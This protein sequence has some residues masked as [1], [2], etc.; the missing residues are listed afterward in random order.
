MGW[1]SMESDPRETNVA[2]V[3]QSERLMGRL[4]REGNDTVFV[5]HY[6]VEE[7][8]PGIAFHLQT[9]TRSYRQGGGAVHPFFAGLLPEGAR[10]T[11][12]SARLKTSLD[13][14]FTLLVAV[15]EDCVGDV[16][17]VP[18]DAPP[19]AP[20]AVALGNPANLDF[21]GLFARSIGQEEDDYDHVALAGVQEK[22]SAAMV[23][24]PVGSSSAILKLSPP[25]LPR[26]VENEAFFLRMA[27]DLGVRVNRAE[28][29]R[30]RH[31]R[32]G[33]MVQ[34]FDRFATGRSGYLS[35]THQE[36]AC[37]FTNVFPA[38]KYRL[39]S[40]DVAEG[41]VAH[42]SVPPLAIREFVRQSAMNYL[43]A[44][45]DFH[46]KN[47][48]L[49]RSPKTGLIEVT[50]AY[51]VLSTLPY[52]DDRMAMK[53]DGR[54]KNLSRRTFVEF[55]ARYGVAPKAIHTLLD[56]MCEA[57]PP[58]IARLE[59]IGFDERPTAHLRREVLRRREQLG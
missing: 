23:S 29:V 38:A 43:I 13:D 21:D 25:R 30:D 40:K 9:T 8:E 44:N 32:S 53:M 51:D 14:M 12:L 5:Y 41:L 7:G 6:S 27:D 34:R 22:V 52:G 20:A 49:Y 28:L 4:E 56:R 48:S 18:V 36:D 31:G 45:G 46:A 55:A 26:L 17:V 11:A 57:S 35:K 33:L 1:S 59:E 3:Y 37:Q 24:F 2:D 54:D 10:L 19:T 16:S 58:W 50:P 15:G 39:T 42:A 47:L